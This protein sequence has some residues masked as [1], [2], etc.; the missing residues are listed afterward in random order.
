MFIRDNHRHAWA[1]AAIAC[2][3]LTAC[4]ADPEPESSATGGDDGTIADVEPPRAWAPLSDP[5]AWAP[6]AASD[7]P[8][9]DERP[10]EVVCA[11]ED[12]WRRE[13]EG[14][15]IDTGACNYLALSQPLPRALAAGEPLRISAW[16]Q[17]LIATA[18]AEGHIAVAVDGVVVWEER[19]AIPGPADARDLIFA[20]PEGAPAGAP[21]TL[22]LHN[23]GANTWRFQGLFA[24]EPAPTGE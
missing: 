19:V 5:L 20:A 23:H 16:W 6:V 24:G 14:V 12:G 17:N 4:D 15:E 13:A 22:H 1:R 21:I 2:A 11:A 8:F 9:A 10:A 3:L 7:D 18:P